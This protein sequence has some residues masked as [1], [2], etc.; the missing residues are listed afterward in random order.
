MWVDL[1]SLPK[2]LLSALDFA[3][4]AWR[5]AWGAQLLFA[6]GVA[7]LI[8]G[9]LSGGE[10]AP[11]TWVGGAV[12]M[13]A[14]APLFGALHMVE[15]VERRRRDLVA[16]GLQIGPV[17]F[18][19][20]IVAASIAA[21]IVLLVLGM[22]ALA[23]MSLVAFAGHGPI[24]L[25]PFGEINLALTAAAGNL[26]L[27]AAASLFVLV[28]L[29]FVWGMAVDDDGSALV[30]SWWATR[31][32]EPLVLGAGLLAVSP[33]L[34][35]VAAVLALDRLGSSAIGAWPLAD[36]VL[37]GLSAGFVAAFVQA[38]VLVGMF[39]SLER[40][41]RPRPVKR[42]SSRRSLFQTSSL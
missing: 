34:L 6:A 18:A 16:F 40:R 11:A 30:R 35:T 37:M 14:W 4:L 39:A 1:R 19:L 26:I 22:A 41:A 27:G 9:L 38:P 10:G 15:R 7:A 8:A 42:R 23:S 5:A 25:G 13:V 28:R 21:V 33:S 24:A 3:A 32:R 20:W 29:A 12:C 36:A 17:E 31:R 2:R